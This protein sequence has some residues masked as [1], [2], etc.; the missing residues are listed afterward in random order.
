LAFG[1]RA[2]HEVEPAGFSGASVN[3]RLKSAGV[4]G[5]RWRGRGDPLKKTV[6]A[7]ASGQPAQQL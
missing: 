4:R 3:H 1:R 7:W 5:P 2:G 6:A